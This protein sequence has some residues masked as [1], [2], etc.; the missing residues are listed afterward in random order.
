VESVKNDG[1]RETWN[2]LFRTSRSVSRSPLETTSA[3]TL[4][5]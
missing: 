5:L 1:V 3:S 4:T 2:Y